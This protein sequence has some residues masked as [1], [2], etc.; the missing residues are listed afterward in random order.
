[1]MVLHIANYIPGYHRGSGGAE[2]AC[3]NTIKALY[4]HGVENVVATVKPNKQ[5]QEKEFDFYPITTSEDLIGWK[6]SFI[7]HFFYFDF[8]SFFSLRKILKKT[9]PDIVHLYNFDLIS[10]SAISAAKSLKIPLVFSVYDYWI[11]SKDKGIT[12][13]D[14]WLR[15]K[16]F[17]H[18]LKK[19]DIMIALSNHSK[20]L[21]AEQGIKE[22]KIEIVP[23]FMEKS[24]KTE[25]TASGKSLIVFLGWIQPRKGLHILVKAMPEIVEKIPEARLCILG[26][27]EETD[28]LDGIIDF[29]KENNLDKNIIWLRNTTKINNPAE[30]YDKMEKA[31][32]VA[33]PEQ[34]PNMSPVIIAESLAIGK[35]VVA[36][37]LGGISD[38]I[39]DGVS[40]LLAD[41]DSPSD[42][43]EKIIKAMSDEKLSAGLSAGAR[44]RHEYL[45]DNEK[46]VFKII[47]IYENII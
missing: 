6:L 10:L 11:F 32:I 19:V 29:I 45:F 3:L 42:F 39:E 33:V 47:K 13:N 21:L 9:K 34:W 17:S 26:M 22:N 23:L 24:E 16:I 31:A 8:V 7:K 2:Q 35:I 27:K 37:R 15:R 38:I 36:S 30:Y 20:I 18:F 25:K 4:A 41:Y 14:G 43:A 44:K 12:F 5:P 40:G 46:N 28:Y 1:M